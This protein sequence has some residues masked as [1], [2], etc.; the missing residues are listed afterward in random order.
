MAPSP[1]DTYILEPTS[2]QSPSLSEPAVSPSREESIKDE[3]SQNLT[4]LQNASLQPSASNSL[5]IHFSTKR[6]AEED[7]KKFKVPR[8]APQESSIRYY[9]REITH[10]YQT[11]DFVGIKEA[12]DIIISLDPTSYHGHKYSADAHYHLNEF[13]EAAV[14]ADMAIRFAPPTYEEKIVIYEILA[15]SKLACGDFV[16]TIKATEQI[17]ELAP[18]YYFAYQAQA[19]AKRLLGDYLG[20]VESAENS[21]KLNPNESQTLTAH[22][23]CIQSYVELKNYPQVI[24]HLQKILALDPDN[25]D[26]KII[27]A[28]TLSYLENRANDSLH[29]EDYSDAIANF[30]LLLELDPN[31]ASYFCNRED[32]RRGIAALGS[33][34]ITVSPRSVNFGALKEMRVMSFR[35]PPTIVLNKEIRRSARNLMLPR[36]W[37]EITLLQ[38]NSTLA[39]TN[40]NTINDLF[41]ELQKWA[42]TANT[43]IDPAITDPVKKQQLYEARV[44]A[45][46]V[47]KQMLK[48]S[49]ELTGIGEATIV[50]L[51]YCMG[52]KKQQ[53]ELLDLIEKL[54]GNQQDVALT[55]PIT[56]K[57]YGRTFPMMMASDPRVIPKLLQWLEIGPLN[58]RSLSHSLVFTKDNQGLT[59]SAWV[60]K[61][62]AY[63]EDICRLLAWLYK[64]TF[65]L[66]QTPNALLLRALTDPIDNPDTPIFD[67]FGTLTLLLIYHS[68]RLLS[69][70]PN[71]PMLVSRGENII[72]CLLVSFTT[73]SSKL[74][75][76]QHNAEN[77]FRLLTIK[78]RNHMTFPMY[79]VNNCHPIDLPLFVAFLTDIAIK[80]QLALRPEKVMELLLSV[81][82]NSDKI[83]L[84]VLFEKIN[85]EGLN[86]LTPT[87][88]VWVYEVLPTAL[89]TS[90]IKT[91]IENPEHLFRIL[92]VKDLRYATFPMYMIN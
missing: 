16:G 85:T 71:A 49:F 91:L 83:L 74:F 44:Y 2:I 80:A 10:K 17:I 90:L 40:F 92:T 81:L 38:Q 77:L 37:S 45:G 47:L 24:R 43:E 53:D 33:F 41:I 52:N 27:Q 26:A 61:N 20:A 58:D 65:A 13:A 51:I 4:D 35:L 31:N 63:N 11:N 79:V 12:A 39:Q 88:L 21:I 86:V 69:R 46:F 62:S 32:A 72:A 64:T 75:F 18:N 68:Q 54:L 42:T 36:E 67:S 56:E 9:L 70:K 25:N 30:D 7:R 76:T 15:K 82:P 5:G 59:F 73:S 8:T 28:H 1:S 48:A 84:K 34:S 57:F 3:D 50:T 66:P 89:A 22:V 55:I 60:A 6:K 23:I 78:D 19:D 87:L 14:T 29:N